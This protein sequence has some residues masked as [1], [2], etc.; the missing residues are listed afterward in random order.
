M[1]VGL[2]QRRESGISRRTFG[3]VEILA[4]KEPLTGSV[5]GAKAIKLT[6]QRLNIEVINMYPR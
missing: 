6:V 2:S 1:Y 5:H 4:G 3:D